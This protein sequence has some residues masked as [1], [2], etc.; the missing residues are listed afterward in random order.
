MSARAQNWE[1]RKRYPSKPGEPDDWGEFHK[2][3]LSRTAYT[4]NLDNVEYRAVDGGEVRIVGLYELIL[5][6]DDPARFFEDPQKY[7][8]FFG[9]AAAYRVIARA[10]RAIGEECPVFVIWRPVHLTESD[11][12]C[13]VGDFDGGP[14][15]PLEREEMSD[16]LENLPEWPPHSSMRIPTDRKEV[17]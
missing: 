7:A 15:Y 9:K 6:P 8:P 16:F 10:L 17:V 4:A 1:G 12:T 14:M 3:F 11:S 2:N 5:I 13:I